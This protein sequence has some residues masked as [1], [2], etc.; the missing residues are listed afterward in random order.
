MLP[1]Q[2]AMPG[3][4]RGALEQQRRLDDWAKIGANGRK[5]L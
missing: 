3:Q 5:R 2:R 1:F 4:V